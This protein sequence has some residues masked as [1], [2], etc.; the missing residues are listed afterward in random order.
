MRSSTSFLN[1]N[2]DWSHSSKSSSPPGEFTSNRAFSDTVCNRVHM[3]TTCAIL[4]RDSHSSENLLSRF[5]INKKFALSDM[6]VSYK[7]S[8]KD[9]IRFYL[10]NMIRS[11]RTLSLAMRTRDEKDDPLVIHSCSLRK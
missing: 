1:I 3:C 2:P 10:V 8:S 9:D 11:T 6:F 7:S 4:L 5:R